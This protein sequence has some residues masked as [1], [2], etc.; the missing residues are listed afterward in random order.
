M[1]IL[2]MGK[3]TKKE[4]T[5]EAVPIEAWPDL[6]HQPSLPH[7]Q[8]GQHQTPASFLPGL[9]SVLH[10]KFPLPAYPA[11]ETLFPGSSQGPGMVALTPVIPFT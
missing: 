11:L 9:L 5:L 6:S 4:A 8:H 10:L 7:P 1:P 3:L 2:Q